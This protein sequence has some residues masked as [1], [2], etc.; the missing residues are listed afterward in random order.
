M[1]EDVQILQSSRHQ[2]LLPSTNMDCL[3]QVSQQH[4]QHCNLAYGKVLVVTKTGRPCTRESCNLDR[5][6]QTQAHV[7]CSTICTGEQTWWYQ[8]MVYSEARPLMANPQ[9]A[10]WSIR[11]CISIFAFSAATSYHYRG[12]SSC[13]AASDDVLIATAVIV[14]QN[15]SITLGDQS[16]VQVH[17]AL[18]MS[19]TGAVICSCSASTPALL[20]TVWC[21]TAATAPL[22][23][24][25]GSASCTPGPGCYLPSKVVLSPS[26][27]Q[28]AVQ[29][30]V[31]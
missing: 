16:K 22:A 27:V 28:D 25:A 3:R 23:C 15:I 29:C 9:T 5:T 31:L 10:C 1:L 7:R 24:C 8:D 26:V 6:F 11:F 4:G 18:G 13:Q 30:S 21:S 19:C 2:G 12:L 14:M 17:D 20:T